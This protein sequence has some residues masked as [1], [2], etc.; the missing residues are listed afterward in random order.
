MTPNRRTKLLEICME[1][2]QKP[3]V[4]NIYVA[5]D[6]TEMVAISYPIAINN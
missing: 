3:E 6:E 5:F 2:S 4:L 1:N